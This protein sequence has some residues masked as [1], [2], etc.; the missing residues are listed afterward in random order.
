[1][2]DE[3]KIDGLMDFLIDG[4]LNRVDGSQWIDRLPTFLQPSHISLMAITAA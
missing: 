3:R 4:R 2:T 1:L